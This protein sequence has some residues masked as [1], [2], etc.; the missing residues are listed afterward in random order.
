MRR[1]V[2][3]HH[4]LSQQSYFQ[5]VA[6]QNDILRNE[7]RELAT[8]LDRGPVHIPVPTEKAPPSEEISEMRYQMKELAR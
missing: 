2:G 7:I 5:N 6:T 3:L 1:F 8:S 4:F